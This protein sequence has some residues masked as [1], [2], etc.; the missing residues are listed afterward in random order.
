[1]RRFNII[2][3][4]VQVYRF[5]IELPDGLTDEEMCDRIHD[6][7]AGNRDDCWSSGEESIVAM[8]EVTEEVRQ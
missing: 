2:I 6:Y 3:E 4:D 8:D 7:C 1:M 5:S